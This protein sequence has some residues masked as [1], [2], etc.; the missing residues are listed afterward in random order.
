[1]ISNEGSIEWPNLEQY[2]DQPIFNTKAAVQLTGVLAPTLRA[3]ERRY[4]LFTPQRADNAYRL[5]SERNVA[6]IRW[7]KERV[8]N[9][10]SIS[11]AVALFRHL[12][13]QKPRADTV[14][15]YFDIPQNSPAAFQVAFNSPIPDPAHI[16]VNEDSEGGLAVSVSRNMVH[17]TASY[18]YPAIGSS[19]PT[20]YNMQ[21][22]RE[23]LIEVFQDMN[24]LEAH[25]LM[26]NMFSLY[27]VEQVCGELIVPTLWDIGRLWAKGQLTVSVE[28]FASNFFR[29][30]LTNMFHVTRGPGYGPLVLA[31]CAPGEPHE[32]SILM[33]ALILRRHGVRVA[34]LGQSI[35][36]ADLLRTIKKVRPAMVCISLTLP[37]YIADVMRLAKQVHTLP[38]PVRPVLVFGGQAFLQIPHPDIL[39]PEGVYINGDLSHIIDSLQSIMHEVAEKRTAQP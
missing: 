8:D 35:E 37:S 14:D 12:E 30:L 13:E 6:L 3:W 21:T 22:T 11:H 1:M 19:Y 18:R 29:A 25:V 5:Y 26:G 9:G 7:L 32:L 17:E 20:S 4:A 36:T 15:V 38:E 28:H 31:C 27:P 16:T 34:Y 24:E 23:Q 2:S 39:I 10:V 33:L